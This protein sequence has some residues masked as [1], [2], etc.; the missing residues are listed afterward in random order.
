MFLVR[1]DEHIAQAMWGTPAAKPQRL[2]LLSEF[3]LI[4]INAPSRW[5]RF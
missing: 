5:A 3:L 1:R 4:W 2:G